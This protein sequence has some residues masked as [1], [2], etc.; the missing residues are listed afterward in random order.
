MPSIWQNY[1]RIAT[2]RRLRGIDQGSQLPAI[3]LRNIL[4]DGRKLQRYALL[5]G[6]SN[7]GVLPLGFPQVMALP[8]YLEILASPDFPLPPMGLVHTANRIDQWRPIRE[9]ESLDFKVIATPVRSVNKGHEFDLL[10]E[11]FVHGT[12]VW[13]SRATYLQKMSTRPL[14]QGIPSTTNNHH[15]NTPPVD[16][17]YRITDHW[18]L[19][20]SLGWQFARLTGDLN[21]IHL[22]RPTAR[23]LGHPRHLI[24][25]MWNV[26]HAMGRFETLLPAYNALM[27]LAVRCSVQF[28]RPL[29]LPGDALLSCEYQEGQ[30]PFRLTSKDLMTTHLT[31][32]LAP[33]TEREKYQ[34]VSKRWE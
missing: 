20:S 8:V 25:G 12:L 21:P 4:T 11:V 2:K 29:Y 34:V 15:K 28:K 5:C 19:P 16:T 14:S 10:T 30:I 22:S 1:W 27:N 9:K 13:R 18:H 31:G 33:L 17:I 23:L 6:L 7:T 3:Q 26:A 32:T 24:H